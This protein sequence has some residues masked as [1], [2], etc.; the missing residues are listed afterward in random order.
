MKSVIAH[1]RNVFVSLVAAVILLLQ[2]CQQ[3]DGPEVMI[4]Q[5]ANY[6][7]VFDAALEVAA[8]AGMPARFVDRRAG[9][10]QTE[11]RI[12]GSVLEPWRTDNSSIGQATANT[13]AFERRRT[14]FEFA[15]VDY[16]DQTLQKQETLT[17]PSLVNENPLVD[18]TQANYPLEIRVWVFLERADTYGLRRSTWSRTKTT[19]ARVI[20]PDTGEQTSGTN[21]TTIT[22]DREYE[23]ALLAR[24]AQKI[25]S[26]DVQ[27]GQDSLQHP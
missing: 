8:E 27:G 26:L 2:A 19:I 1:C 4:V 15:P 18:L 12:A 5:P 22:R 10:V 25:Q 23:K 11:T 14:R 20:D 21:W 24:V 7:V 17:G 6:S 3:V 9:I 13:L 16:Q